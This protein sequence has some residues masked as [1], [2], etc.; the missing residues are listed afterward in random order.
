MNSF[1]PNL[2]STLVLFNTEYKWSSEECKD[3][4]IW[5]GFNFNCSD[6][7]FKLCQQMTYLYSITVD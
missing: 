3:K 7:S 5:V 2:Y 6:L 1:D 4:M